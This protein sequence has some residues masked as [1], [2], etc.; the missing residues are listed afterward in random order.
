MNLED[1]GY[2]LGLLVGLIGLAGIVAYGARGSILK[3]TNEVL[4]GA[5]H[6]ERTERAEDNR[7]H[8]RD[9]AVLNAKVETLSRDFA[10]VIASGIVEV[11]RDEGVLPRRN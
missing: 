7:R 5:L 2:L 8:E 6:V 4:E 1:A 11:M 9:L 3:T 10:K